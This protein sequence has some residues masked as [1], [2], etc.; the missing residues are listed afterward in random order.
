MINAKNTVYTV[1]KQSTVPEKVRTIF[2][3][4]AES[5]A[6]KQTS[7]AERASHL[8]NELADPIDRVEMKTNEVASKTFF[9]WLY[10]LFTP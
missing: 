6:M 4:C 1:K 3:D 10:K 7:G 8:M 5:V 2:A 9:T